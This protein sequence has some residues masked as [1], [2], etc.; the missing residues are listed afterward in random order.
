MNAEPHKIWTVAEAKARLSEILRLASTE[1]PQ[2]IGTKVRYVI[3][4]EEEWLKR[5]EPQIP[6]GRYLVEN[7]PRGYDDLELPDR[8]EPE[9]P[10]LFSDPESAGSED[11]K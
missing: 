1:G 3:V 8:A 10:P 2:R 9:R 5:E 7:L 4:P 11:R 6:L